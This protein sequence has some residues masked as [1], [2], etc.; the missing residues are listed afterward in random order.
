M[1]LASAA[2]ALPDPK[3]K[4]R[5]YEAYRRAGGMHSRGDDAE[6]VRE[7]RT[8]LADSPGMVDAWH[9]LGLSLFRM[10]RT[11]EATAAL[12][13]VVK[14]EPTHAG[15]HLALARIQAGEGQPDRARRHAELASASQ[16]G[17]AFETLAELMLRTGSRPRPRPTRSGAS[18]RMGRAW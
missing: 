2:G 5:V 13:E 8:V 1:R 3:D 17:E 14:I 11:A 9:L 18:T 6:A 7:L 10:G 16:P 4:V 12:E 15:A